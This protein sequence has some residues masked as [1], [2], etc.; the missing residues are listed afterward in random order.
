MWKGRQ[1]YPEHKGELTPFHALMTL[2][3]ATVGTGNIV[4]VASAGQAQCSEC[5]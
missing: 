5:G 2:L 3:V 1:H 4:G